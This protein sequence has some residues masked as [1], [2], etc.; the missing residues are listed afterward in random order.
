MGTWGNGNFGD[1][2]K[3]LVQAIKLLNPKA[4]QAMY[5][6][7]RSQTIVKGN[8]N[9]CAFNKAGEQISMEL[10]GTIKETVTSS[11]RAAEVFGLS[12]MVVNKFIKAWDDLPGSDEES[13]KILIE[14]LERVGLF[15]EAGQS[16]VTRKVRQVLHENVERKLLEELEKQ[17]DDNKVEGVCEAGELLFAGV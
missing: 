7:A 16:R 3:P 4:K 14:C 5:G 15:S 10:G 11:E 13:T 17:L 9:G 8:W 12:V 1:P 6:A 2:H